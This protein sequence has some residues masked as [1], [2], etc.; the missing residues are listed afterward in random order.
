MNFGVKE[1]MDENIVVFSGDSDPE[2]RREMME[3]LRNLA[4]ALENGTNVG[5]PLL[6]LEE[7]CL[8]RLKD[9]T[10][11]VAEAEKSRTRSGGA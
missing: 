5:N 1:K 10:R 11:Q 3:I 9:A 2:E 7:H 8:R 4:D 6:V